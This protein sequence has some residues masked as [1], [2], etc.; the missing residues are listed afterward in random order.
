MAIMAN[1]DLLR[2]QV[3]ADPRQRRLVDGA[4]QGAQRGAALTQR[5]LAFARRQDLQPQAV[6]VADLVEGMLQL[7]GQSI[8]P[9]VQVA[10]EKATDNGMVLVDPDQLER[11]SG[12]LALFGRDAMPVGGSISIK[13]AEVEITDLGATRA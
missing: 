10:F 13:V 2:R 6:N 5:L 8:G 4:M 9:R 3:D 11:R 7:L 12:S 1:L